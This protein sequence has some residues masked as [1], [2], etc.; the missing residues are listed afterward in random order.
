MFGSEYCR[1]ICC[2]SRD[3]P[4]LTSAF[5][6]HSSAEAFQN[7]AGYKQNDVDMGGE[8]ENHCFAT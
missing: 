1:N 3:L 6:S 4:W 8:L 7:V 5:A 2:C